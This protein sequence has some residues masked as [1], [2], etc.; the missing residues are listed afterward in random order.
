MK[1]YAATDLKQNLGD[2][3]AVANRE[4]VSITRHNKTRYVLMSIEAY[5]AHFSRDPR[6]AFS[7]DEAPDE[8]LEMI[9]EALGRLEEQGRD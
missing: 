3:L 1:T 7:L 9:E 4:P 8:H 6:R 5:E 2:V